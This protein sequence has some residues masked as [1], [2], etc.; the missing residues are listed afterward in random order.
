MHITAVEGNKNSFFKKASQIETDLPNG[1]WRF[2]KFVSKNEIW[3]LYSDHENGNH[4]AHKDFFKYFLGQFTPQCPTTMSISQSS[5]FSEF[6]ETLNEVLN[7]S[8]EV[9]DLSVHSLWIWHAPL[10]NKSEVVEL[11]KK[12]RSYLNF[13]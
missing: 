8:L 9:Y 11:P 6:C 13:D 10:I 3:A 7:K 12:L 2:F 4:K 5:D 1:E